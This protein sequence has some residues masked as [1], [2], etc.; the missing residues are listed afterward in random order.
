MNKYRLVKTEIGSKWDKFVDDSPNGTYFSSSKYLKSLSLNLCPYY[1]YKKEHISAAIICILSSDSKSIVGNDLV[2]YDGIIFEDM[3]HL[4]ISQKRSEIFKIQTYVAE[5]LI[6]RYN[7]IKFSLHHTIKDIRPF[8]WVNYKLSNMNTF[9][10]YNKYTSI[11]DIS[12]FNY[13]KPF[14]ELSLYKNSSVAR[15][16]EIRYAKKKNV[17]TRETDNID[18]FLNFYRRT[19]DRQNIKVE[20]KKIGQ[21]ERLI[22]SL[23]IEK[24]MIMLESSNAELEIGSMAIFLIDSRWAFYLFG[25]NDPKMR[26]QHTGTAII[27]D[28]FFILRKLGIKKL[29]LE[30]VN[31]PNR[32][33][34]KLSFG[35]SL[36]NYY[37]VNKIITD[38]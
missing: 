25:A 17:I 34:F 22:K 30:G 37:E 24:R 19:L 15:R 3:S 26:N 14:E 6:L 21:M 11:V 32:G 9:S 36:E 27:W 16:Q 7:Q 1:C 10:V 5:E 23:L 18:K 2:I 33:W 31:S 28:A 35:G 13:D 4:N 38:N 8:L 12:E 29:D 20:N